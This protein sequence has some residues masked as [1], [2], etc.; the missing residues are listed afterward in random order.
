MISLNKSMSSSHLTWK[1]NR[2]IISLPCNFSWSPFPLDECPET[3]TLLILL[4]SQTRMAVEV[5][6]PALGIGINLG[7][8]E[9]ASDTLAMPFWICS[10]W[11]C[12]E[13]WAIEVDDQFHQKNL[14]VSLG[15][16]DLI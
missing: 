6:I 2:V 15:Q 13:I 7:G 9:G 4:I 10:P 8:V 3:P 12:T 14:Q 5:Q 1:Q 11:V 16:G